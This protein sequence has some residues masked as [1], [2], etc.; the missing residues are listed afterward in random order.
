MSGKAGSD[1]TPGKL[2]PLS[3]IIAA[4]DEEENLKVFLP[5]ILN[6]DYPEFELIVALDRCVDDSIK[7]VQDL[8]MHF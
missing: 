8:Q 5:R 4:R 3:V 1:S 7:V 2:P 6:Q